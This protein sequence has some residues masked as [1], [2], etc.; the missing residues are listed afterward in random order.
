[1]CTGKYSTHLPD[2]LVVNILSYML[3]ISL[4]QKLCSYS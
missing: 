4:E 2:A 1:M 3:K